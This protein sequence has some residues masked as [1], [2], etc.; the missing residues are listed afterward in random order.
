M[1]TKARIFINTTGGEDSLN[2][3]NAGNVQG[4][5][6]V[7]RA[8]RKYIQRR[9]DLELATSPLDADYII[10]FD[11]FSEP[12][13]GPHQNILYFQNVYPPH[14]WPGGTVGQF[15]LHKHKFDQF[16]YTSKTLKEHC[17]IDGGMIPFATD[18]EI[19]CPQSPREKYRH[20]ACFVGNGIRTSAENAR[21]IFPIIDDIAI[22][23]NPVGWGNEYSKACKGKLPLEDEPVLYSTTHACLNFHLGEHVLHDTINF[24]IYNILACCGFIISDKIPSL[25][26]AEYSQFMA[27]TT[28]DANVKFLLDSHASGSFGSAAQHM[29]IK[30]HKYVLEHDTFVQRIET[31]AQFIKAL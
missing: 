29:A 19:F 23:G 1:S 22:Y 16:I 21:Y 17:G 2:I 13:S 11:L 10:Y 30:G 25:V 3:E 6:M 26:D 5:Q 9:D 24:R 4:D 27:L 28:G 8:W 18:H 14:A 20:K 15:H 12:L 31:L 7:A